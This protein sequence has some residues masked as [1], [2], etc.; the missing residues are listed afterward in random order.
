MSALLPAAD[1]F[2]IRLKGDEGD[3]ARLSFIQYIATSLALSSYAAGLLN[4]DGWEVAQAL[5]AKLWQGFSGQVDIQGQLTVWLVHVIHHERLN[6]LAYCNMGVCLCMV[7]FHVL[8]YVFLGELRIIE[9]HTLRERCI[10]YLLFKIIFLGAVVEPE[11]IE[12]ICWSAC[13]LVLGV[14]KMLGLL[15]HDRFEFI[16]VSHNTSVMDHVRLTTLLCLVFGSCAVWAHSCFYTFWDGAGASVVLLLMFECTTCTI[17]TVQTLIKY[18]V[19][20]IN[21][22]VYD[23]EWSLRGPLWYFIGFVGGTSTLLI[24]AVHYFHVWSINGISLNLVDAILFLNIRVTIGN[25]LKNITGWLN[26]RH[27]MRQLDTAWPDATAAE[28]EAIDENCGICLRHMHEAKRLP[29]NHYFHRG[30][31][32]RLMEGGGRPSCPI[33]RAPLFPANLGGS[34]NRGAS[35][36]SGNLGNNNMFARGAM[37][38]INLQ[39][40]V[41]LGGNRRR[42]RP[43]VRRDPRAHEAAVRAL[44]P[45]NSELLTS[46]DGPDLV[47]GQRLVGREIRKRFGLRYYGGRVV[48]VWE[49]IPVV[50]GQH[51][52][53]R[54]VMYRVDY[55]DGD[56]EDMIWN[57][58]SR[59]L[60]GITVSPS[61]A[62]ILTNQA[63]IEMNRADSGQ[64]A[65]VGSSGGVA[66]NAIVIC[67][68]IYDWTGTR[69][70]L[71]RFAEATPVSEVAKAYA[72]ERGLDWGNIT[73]HVFDSHCKEAVLV[74]FNST[75]ASTVRKCKCL[76]SQNMPGSGSNEMVVNE[77]R[78]FAKVK[79]FPRLGEGSTVRFVAPREMLRLQRRRQRQAR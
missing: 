67:A 1:R 30:C 51:I 16:A 25:M 46:A 62:S 52:T 19:H 54:T 4:Q 78:I 13:F 31:L 35:P 14:M 56:R 64:T 15:A 75:L 66:T 58:L 45:N 47:Q 9:D 36:F 22:H 48:R 29:C 50:N 40:G 57:E 70:S 17:S 8:A 7:F 63:G 6:L 53:Q 77:C 37:P 55:E 43:P 79:E 44:F 32:Q 24:S 39:I 11:L 41:N 72:T 23:G 49:A 69:P 12:L 38:R 21:V 27:M 59:L 5:M 26:Y 76:R 3:M 68:R 20:G 2:T 65:G 71:Y 74:D 60:V 61:G 73:L 34:G 42:Q 28:L 18:L 10:N 33:C